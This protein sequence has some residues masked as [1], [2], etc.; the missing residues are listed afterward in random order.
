[1]RPGRT[2]HL[3]LGPELGH[4]FW[5]MIFVEA[6]FGAYMS[7][8]PLWIEALGAPVTVVG[9]VL[10]SSGLLRL[11]TLGPSANLAERFDARR[12]IVVARCCAGL[13]MIAAALANHWPQLFLMVQIG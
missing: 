12:L 9:L 6:A 4:V 3:G 13:G 1:M 10:G 8:W 11:L 2:W 5:A 7:V